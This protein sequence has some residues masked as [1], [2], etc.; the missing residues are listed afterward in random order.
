MFVFF[1]ALSESLILYNTWVEI[2]TPQLYKI[3]LWFR[4]KLENSYNFIKFENSYIYRKNT[5]LST[6]KYIL[7]GA[8]KVMH[9]RKSLI[10]S[11]RMDI[12]TNLLSVICSP[13]HDLKCQDK[14]KFEIL[15]G[16]ELCL[17]LYCKQF[18]LGTHLLY[19]VFS[20]LQKGSKRCYSKQK[21]N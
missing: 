8:P 6:P 11:I 10:S 21:F 4:W 9:A 19:V 20:S 16:S 2:K 18:G 14:K 5:T 17:F 13:I 3:Y 7:Q 15:I 12:L 1:S